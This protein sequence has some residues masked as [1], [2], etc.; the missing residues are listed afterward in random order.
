[1]DLLSFLISVIIFNLLSFC[2]SQVNLNGSK[3][4]RSSIQNSLSMVNELSIVCRVQ[5]LF[6]LRNLIP[7]HNINTDYS[8]IC[9]TFSL[10]NVV[11]VYTV[12]AGCIL[13]GYCAELHKR[14][15]AADSCPYWC[16]LNL[17]TARRSKKIWKLSL[18]EVGCG[19]LVRSG[20]GALR[21]KGAPALAFLLAQTF[22]ISAKRATRG[23]V[24]QGFL[25]PTS[26]SN[27]AVFSQ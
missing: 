25:S 3:T 14:K 5:F 2:V 23:S 8:I 9:P 19:D 26:S 1:M 21:E 11:I 13:L 15:S 6:V 20:A 12:K 18:Q 27:S 7:L 10:Y 22:W 4:R 16:Y 24:S 17:I